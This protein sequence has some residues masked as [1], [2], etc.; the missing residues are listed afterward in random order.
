MASGNTS[1]EMP[2]VEQVLEKALSGEELSS[3]M[4]ILNGKILP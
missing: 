3:V 4:T 1:G 2:G